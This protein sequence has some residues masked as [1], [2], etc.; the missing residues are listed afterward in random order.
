MAEKKKV[1]RFTITSINIASTVAALARTRRRLPR[2]RRPR[3]HHLYRLS[4]CVPPPPYHRAPSLAPGGG[5]QEQ[6]VGG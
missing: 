3:L 6:A 2:L 5:G 4:R 1:G